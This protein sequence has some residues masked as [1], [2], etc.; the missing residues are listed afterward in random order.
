MICYDR[1]RTTVGFEQGMNLVNV[2]WEFVLKPLEW[3][4]KRH[5]KEKDEFGGLHNSLSDDL[6]IM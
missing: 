4:E 2:L 1:Q 6:E 3:I 5:Q